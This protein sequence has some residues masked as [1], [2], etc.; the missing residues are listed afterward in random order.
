MKTIEVVAAIVFH[1]GKVLCVQRGISELNYISEK[2]EFPGGK[3][4]S[5][6]TLEQAIAR[7]I[8]EELK[9]SV[10]VKRHFLTVEH[11]YPDFNLIMHSFICYTNSCN[12]V[13]T[14]HLQALWL[15]ID[16][17]DNLDWAAADIPIVQKL[18]ESA[19]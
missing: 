13:L 17:L 5:N 16:E 18:K 15:R 2:F 14:E 10:C 8:A 9:M 19:L 3:L 11:S 6:E 4:E 7:E 12:L 1:Q